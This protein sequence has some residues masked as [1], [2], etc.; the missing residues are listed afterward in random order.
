MPARLATSVDE[1]PVFFEA[2]REVLFGIATQP[3]VTSKRIDV[4]LAPVGF[5]V[6]G[7]HRNQ[8]FMQLARR[9]AASGYTTIRIDYRGVGESSGNVVIWEL[10]NSFEP[11]LIGAADWLRGQGMEEIVLVGTCFGGRTSRTSRGWRCLPRR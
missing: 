1:V 5:G 7:E 6:P 10:E 9:L 3:T 2:G 8:M 4:V 11:D